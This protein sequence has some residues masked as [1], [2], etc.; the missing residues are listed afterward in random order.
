MTDHPLGRHCD[1][2]K[3]NIIDFMLVLLITGVKQLLCVREE[4]FKKLLNLEGECE[5][6]IP[7]SVRRAGGEDNNRRRGG[8][9][10][11]WKW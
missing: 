8:E 6:E 10:G 2:K 1:A 3:I 9:S 5:I 7:H 11:E 4:Y